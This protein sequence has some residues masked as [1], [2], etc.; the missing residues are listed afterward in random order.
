MLQKIDVESFYE[1]II[2]T[3]KMFE[4]ISEKNKKLEQAFF[5]KNLKLKLEE[6]TKFLSLVESNSER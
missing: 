1:N 5:N 6:E 3:N 4:T 2:I